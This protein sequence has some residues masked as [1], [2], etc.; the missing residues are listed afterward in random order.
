MRRQKSRDNLMVITVQVLEGSDPYPFRIISFPPLDFLWHLLQHLPFRLQLGWQLW[1]YELD[2]KQQE[3]KCASIETGFQCRPQNHF[4]TGA[5]H[6][7]LLNL[8]KVLI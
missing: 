4:L 6:F 1:C 7:P 5:C 8:K 3:V 2:L